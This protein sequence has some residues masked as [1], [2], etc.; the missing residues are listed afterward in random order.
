M[1]NNIT[2]TN[3]D[4]YI[5]IVSFTLTNYKSYNILSLILHYD[6]ND[7]K[8]NNTITCVDML[9]SHNYTSIDIDYIKHK[10]M[11]YEY[12]KD[13]QFVFINK[14]EI[15][16]KYPIRNTFIIDWKI[17]QSKAIMLYINVNNCNIDVYSY[18]VDYNISD[19][20]NYN[21]LYLSRF[22]HVIPYNMEPIYSNHKNV[23]DNNETFNDFV[24]VAINIQ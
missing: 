10:M 19:E 5:F 20:T 6:N 15:I 13:E 9:Y 7:K 11:K 8:Y 2:N 18:D 22:Y 12:Y 14:T 24:D 1:I 16:I 23:F 17:T 21:M 3:H 4:K